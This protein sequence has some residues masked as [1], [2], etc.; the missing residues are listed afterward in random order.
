M[1]KKHLLKKF[2]LAAAV[3]AAPVVSFAADA[4]NPAWQF[5]VAPYLWAANMNGRIGIGPVTAHLSQ[6]FADILSQLNIGGMLWLGAHKGPFGLFLNSM[7]IVLDDDATIDSIKVSERTRFGLF[8]AGI[9]YILLQKQF[10]Q[11]RLQLEPYVGDRYTLNNVRV[12]VLDRSVSDDHH[13]QNPI[14]GLRVTYDW[15]P[16]W[17]LQVAGDAGGT[18]HSSNYSYN[19]VGLVGYKPARFQHAAFYLGY[20]NLYQVYKTGRGLNYFNWNMRQFGPLLG[21]NFS[22]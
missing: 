3:F 15:T 22:F 20:R 8:T 18:N 21:V 13:W 17:V 7:Y 5:D 1:M 10:D 12:N 9:S 2:I 11:A 19:V 6:D 14:V 16:R 4:E